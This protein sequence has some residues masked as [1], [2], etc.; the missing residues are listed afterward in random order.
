MIYAYVRVSTDRQSTEN[1]KFE[2]EKYC[3][4]EELAIDEWVIETVSGTKKSSERL[5]GGLIERLK[6]DD[7]LLVAELSR[8]GRKISDFFVVVDFCLLNKVTVRGIKE[9]FH[10]DQKTSKYMAIVFGMCAEI[11]RDMIAERTREALARR[12]QE[13]VILGRRVGSKSATVKLDSKK[14]TILD[15]IYAKTSKIEIC[16]ILEADRSTLYRYLRR[17]VNAGELAEELI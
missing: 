7:V 6:T 12:K 2:I 17:L 4:K 10:S 9:G 1:Q 14:E 13:G 5:L 16:R 3:R 11:E 8:L 15:L